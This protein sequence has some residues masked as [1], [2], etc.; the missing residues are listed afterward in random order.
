MVLGNSDSVREGDG[1]LVTGF[2]LG[3]LIGTF[4]VTHRAWVAAIAPIAI[5][6]AHSS[7]LDPARVRRLQDGAF[8]IFQLDATI[9]PGN[10]GSPL[11]DPLSGEVVGMANMTLVRKLREGETA[12]PSGISYAVPIRH[13]RDLI[14]SVR[15]DP[16]PGRP[17]NKQ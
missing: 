17:A 12:L 16:Q 8:P 3:T 9:F 1:L 7:Q 10:S 6:R 5:P 13:L 4:P 14:N 11:Y 15:S 2:P